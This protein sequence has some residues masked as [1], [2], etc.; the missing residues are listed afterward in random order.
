MTHQQKLQVGLQKND[1]LARRKFNRALYGDTI[2]GYAAELS[3]Y[4]QLNQ[5]DMQAH[6]KQMYQPSNCT[7]LVAGRVDDTLL[8][9]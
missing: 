8:G 1:M 2:Y 6:F 4:E 3:D 9:K 7:I 5:S